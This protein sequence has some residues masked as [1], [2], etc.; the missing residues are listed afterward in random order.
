ML[1]LPLVCGDQKPSKTSQIQQR[2]KTNSAGSEM[3]QGSEMRKMRMRKASL[4]PH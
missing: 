4:Y 3:K 2:T 1:L